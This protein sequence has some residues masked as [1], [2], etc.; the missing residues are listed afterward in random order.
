M[1]IYTHIY[2]YINMIW[3]Y[4]PTTCCREN[5]RQCASRH[6]S[7]IAAI[8]FDLDMAE[9]L[10]EI[11][12]LEVTRC[13]LSF[14][15]ATLINRCKVLG[16]RRKVQELQARWVLLP[17]WRNDFEK[18]LSDPVFLGFLC[19]Y[20]IKWRVVLEHTSDSEL[21]MVKN[22]IITVLRQ[23]DPASLSQVPLA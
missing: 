20:D 2:T 19:L 5:F 8:L 23:L 13:C 4:N 11:Q 10:P 22:G 14:H 1:Y 3:V 21:Q 9:N 7:C 12:N 17:V 18:I 6:S 16:L 15:L